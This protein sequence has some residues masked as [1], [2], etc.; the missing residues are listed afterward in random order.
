MSPLRWVVLMLGSLRRCTRMRSP[1]ARILC[2]RAS[3]PVSNRLAALMKQVLPRAT[4]Q[5]DVLCAS[6]S[7][8]AETT[9]NRSWSA[10]MHQRS[11]PWHHLRVRA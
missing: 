6:A 4:Q 10:C 3:S 8:T 1:G 9:M 7:L 5:P 2:D 11:A